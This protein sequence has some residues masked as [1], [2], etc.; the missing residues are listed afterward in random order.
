PENV[1]IITRLAQH[2]NWP[3]RVRATNAL[4]TIGTTDQT[5]LLLQLLCDAS[6]WVRYRAAQ[7][8]IN[9]YKHDPGSLTSAINAINDPYAKDMMRQVQEEEVYKTTGLTV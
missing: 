1:D 6:W 3:V 2:P 4:K 7:A 9:V 5:D 8:L